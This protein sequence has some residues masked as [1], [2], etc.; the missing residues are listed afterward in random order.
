[1]SGRLGTRSA[2]L[3]SE[4]WS[5]TGSNWL[6]AVP[7]NDNRSNRDLE[8]STIWRKSQ[9]SALEGEKRITVIAHEHFTDTV[10]SRL[11]KRILRSRKRSDE[12]MA[13]SPTANQRQPKHDFPPC[14]EL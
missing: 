6:G 11:T 2:N 13:I 14:L 9:L 7:S 4:G 12:A 5:S 3:P 1:M 8:L 10:A